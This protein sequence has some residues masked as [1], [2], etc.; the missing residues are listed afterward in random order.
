MN[1]DVI[2]KSKDLLESTKSTSLAERMKSLKT[3]IA[4][5]SRNKNICLLCDTSGSMNSIVVNSE[6]NTSKRAIDILANVLTNFT[7]ANIYSFNTICRKVDSLPEP[8]GS[9][10][11]AEAFT[12]IKNDGIKE[13]I[14]LTDGQP[15]DE[16]AALKVAQGLKINIIYI[17]P[18]PTPQFLI[19]LAKITGGKFDSVELL[20]QGKNADNILENKIRGF[21]NA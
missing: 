20:L 7:G 5:M 8:T 18:T 6:D 12:T 1:E 15:D 17:G 16:R 2:K 21:L 3:K 14:L 10:D 19:D 4:G 13:L 11:L 9:T